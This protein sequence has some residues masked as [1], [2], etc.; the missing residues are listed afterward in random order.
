MKTLYF[1]FEIIGYLQL[2]LNRWPYHPL[3]IVRFSFLGTLKLTFDQ[4]TEIQQH[5]L[6]IFENISYLVPLRGP[7]DFYLACLLKL[8]FGSDKARILGSIKSLIKLT[9]NEKNEKVLIHIDTALIQRL[10]QLLLV[11]DE[12]LVLN[13]LVCWIYDLIL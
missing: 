3:L 4:D 6:D 8:I 1:L 11:P 2:W 12:D 13:I 10:L 7:S 9:L 5:A